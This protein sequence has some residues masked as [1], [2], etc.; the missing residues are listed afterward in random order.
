MPKISI[1]ICVGNS[2]TLATRQPFDASDVAKR[3]EG[4][5]TTLRE[6]TW[7]YLQLQSKN[8]TLVYISLH[9]E[10]CLLS[11]RLGTCF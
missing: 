3:L 8:T 2:K 10:G 1:E 4:R 11:Q 9:L 7:N 6:G 5:C